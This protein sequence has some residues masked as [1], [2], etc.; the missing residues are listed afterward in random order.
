MTIAWSVLRGTGSN[1]S[2]GEQALMEAGTRYVPD[3]PLCSLVH[4]LRQCVLMK[5]PISLEVGRSGNPQRLSGRID[6]LQQCSDWLVL[7]QRN[8]QQWVP[9]RHL[10]GI[11]IVPPMGVGSS[12]R[13][14]LQAVDTRG[15]VQLCLQCQPGNQRDTA[16]WSAMMVGLEASAEL[17]M[18][19]C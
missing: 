1:F 6:S 14:R 10:E 3:L 4:V 17:P 9:T 2:H 13:Y 7:R 5:L 15:A 18:S 19:F 11:C 8:R 12:R 16:I